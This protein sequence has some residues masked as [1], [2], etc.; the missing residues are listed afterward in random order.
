[1]QN[2]TLPLFTE[3]PAAAALAQ[4]IDELH[5]ATAIYTSEPAVDQL[6]DKINWP[7]GDA[8][9]AD[10]S[11]GDG[12]FLVRA[13]TKLLST[14]HVDD[15]KLPQ[16]IQ[17]WEIHPTA[18]SQARTRLAAV[19]IAF[20]RSAERANVIAKKIVRNQD[21]LTDGPNFPC[22][23][24]LMG[25]P[26]Y[27]RMVSVP[28]LLRDEYSQVVPKYAF[29]DLM[30]SF[31]DRSSKVLKPGGQM[32]FIVSD[33]WLSNSGAAALREALG[34][35][36]AIEHI[37]RVDP[38]SVFHRAKQRRAGTPA[39]VHPVLVIFGPV[40]QAITKAAIY[41]GI[42]PTK[43][44]SYPTLD[45]IAKIRIAPWL[46]AAGIWTLSEDQVRA[47]GI[48]RQFLVPAVDTDD[49]RGSELGVPRRVAIRT[50]PNETPCDAVMQHLRSQMPRM[51][52]RGRRVLQSGKWSPPER[53]HNFDLSQPSLLIPRIAKTPKAVRLPIAVLPL[54]HNLSIVSSGP[55]GLKLVERALQS[56]VAA[57][58]MRDH[59]PRLEG[60]YYSLCTTLLRQMP[61]DLA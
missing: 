57:E 32:G 37:E 28:A 5:A 31:L 23:N 58:W 33:R 59:A 29:L 30:F 25:N 38:N 50:V 35:R 4:A 42:D 26:P 52:E 48:P 3:S 56:E 54:N 24:F 47:S 46:D 9:I 45:S 10:C 44:A 36:L 20:G 12:Q 11:A 61:V 8:S 17:G 34:S 39:R 6:L 18:A 27:M 49:I 51:S 15:D 14:R 55:A 16:L 13:L 53:F 2:A 41:P 43:Y 21:F 60:G 40:G 22:I 1:M 19:L 7:N